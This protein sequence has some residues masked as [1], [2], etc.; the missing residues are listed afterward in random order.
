MATLPTTGE[1]IDLI[2]FAMGE[3]PSYTHK[4]DIDRSR[5]SGMTDNQDALIQ[6]V[7]LI[8]NV[9]RYVYP[10]YSHNYGVEL[11]DLIG[12]PKDY[13]M[14]EAK[15]R[16]TEALMQDDRITAAGCVLPLSES[17]R[18]HADL[19]TRHRAGVGMSEATDAVV[20]IVS[21]ETGVISV[22]VGGILKRHLAPKTLERLLRNEL[23]HEQKD[24][25]EN[26]V[27]K[28]RQKL[29]MNEKGGKQK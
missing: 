14:S 5:V 24:Q 10:I 20:V 16:I 4:L 28:L 18:L 1:N 7:Y 8:L 12:Q 22:A 15:R 3:Q 25:N 27:L 19:G 26:I 29:H 6:A 11:A 9:E 2:N 21:E 23:C 13:A 17:E